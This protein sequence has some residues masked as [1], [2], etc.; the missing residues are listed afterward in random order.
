MN[1]TTQSASSALAAIP[2]GG[3][4]AGIESASTFAAATAKATVEARY[5][6]ALRMPRNWDQVRADM[7]KEC[8]RPSFARN[9]ST[10]YKKP[11]GQG[12]EGFGIRF[13][14]MAARCLRNL[15][16]ENQIVFEDETKEVHKLTLTDLE[17]NNTFPEDYKV[18]KTVERSKPRDDGSY[19][20][21]RTNSAGKLTYTIIADDEDL[22]N[23]RGA[24][25]SKAMR[26]IILRI[27]PGDILDECKAEIMAVRGNAAAT[28]PDGERKA[29]V[30]DFASINV[31]PVMLVEYLGHDI[32]QCSPAQLVDLRD[33]YSA[34]AEGEASWKQAMENK[35]EGKPIPR[36]P[37]PPP[38]VAVWPDD[39]FEKQLRRWTLAVQQRLKTVPEILAMARSKGALT[40]EQEKAI[41]AIPTAPAAAQAPAADAAGPAPAAQS[42]ADAAGPPWDTDA[43]P[44]ADAAGQ[45]DTSTAATSTTEASQ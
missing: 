23:K 4:V 1:A 32:A 13:A 39:S 20:S 38:A 24:L 44:A 33:L 19:V 35:A 21:V 10:W 22:L 16:V 9:K 15:M 7:L 2:Q 3:P 14:E 34:I 8:R 11:I 43:T 28:D 12:V 25:K 31:T 5:L 18:S 29:L 45:P 40:A 26:N 27:V 41:N 42:T 37:A 6:M 30:D 17:N 36:A